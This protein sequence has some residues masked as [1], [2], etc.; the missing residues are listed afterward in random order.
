ML[1]ILH[2]AVETVPDAVMRAMFAARKSVFVDLLKWNV[3]VL[4]D[5]YESDQFDDHHAQYLVLTDSTG[6]HLA[7]ARLLPTVRPH[8]LGTLYPQLCD[9]AVPTGP[10]IFEIT[11]FCLDRRLRAAERRI[12]R[13]TLVTALADHALRHGIASYTAIAEL[14]WFQ[15]I[16]AFGWDCLP[17][18]LPRVI[19]GAPLA[20]LRITITQQTPALLAAAGILPRDAYTGHTRR[21]AA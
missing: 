20:A 18:G 7:S 5:R 21:E 10:D 9:D 11:R 19:D 2:P 4:D 8:I 16:L 14:A 17:L 6:A 3:P 12:V 13:D 15:Q 1:H